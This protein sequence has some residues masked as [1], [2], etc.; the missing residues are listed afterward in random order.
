M[1]GWVTAVADNPVY[2]GLMVFV[3]LYPLVS[4]L[5]WIAGAI[6][7]AVHR[8]RRAT[9]SARQSRRSGHFQPAATTRWCDGNLAVRHRRFRVERETGRLGG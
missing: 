8:E 9:E 5:Y 1:T 4:G 2:L 6:L 7:F 3:G